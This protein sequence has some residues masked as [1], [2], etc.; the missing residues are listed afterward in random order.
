MSRVVNLNLNLKS[1]VSNVARG[2]VVLVAL[3]N[4]NG[5]IGLAKKNYLYPEGIVRFAG[6]GVVE[7]ESL[8]DAVVRETEEELQ[9][10]VGA[11]RFSHILDFNVS[12]FV[13]THNKTYG[14]LVAV[15]GFEVKEDEVLTP[16][17]DITGIVFLD[18]TEQ[19]KLV[20]AYEN[21]QGVTTDPD[22]VTVNWSDYGKLFG[23]I[24]SE[25]FK[26]YI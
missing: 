4:S 17:D 7:G 6:G 21:L 15:F 14:L 13:E 20:S 18:K 8:L 1:F 12:A 25:V 22:G 16:S 23:P 10:K 5:E 3:K 11:D 26:S 19:E 24:H 9:L 2:K